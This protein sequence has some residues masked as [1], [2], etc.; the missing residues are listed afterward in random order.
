MSE[1]FNDLIYELQIHNWIDIK[2]LIIEFT[3]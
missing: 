1:L 3:E 2:K